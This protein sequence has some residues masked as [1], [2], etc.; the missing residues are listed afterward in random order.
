MNNYPGVIRSIWLLLLTSLGMGAMFAQPLMITAAWDGLSFEAFVDQTEAELK[1]RVF[2]ESFETSL[3]GPAT[4]PEPVALIP[5]LN[6]WLAPVGLSA[7][8]D[9]NGSVLVLSGNPIQAD[10]PQSIYP[11]SQPAAPRSPRDEPLSTLALS[12]EVI[13]KVFTVGTRRDGLGQAQV[14]LTGEVVDQESGEPIP[15]ASLSFLN[16]DRGA[17]TDEA[18]RFQISL[19]RGTHTLVIRNLGHEEASVSV[20]LLSAGFMTVQLVPRAIQLEDVVISSQQDDP[21][22][23][24]MMGFERIQARAAKEIPVVLGESDLLKV[25]NLLPG[26][27]NVGEGSGGYNVRGAP[28]D[29]NMFYLEQVPVYNTSHM[30]G[31]FSA[32]HSGALSGFSLYKSNIPSEY[33]GRLAATFELEAREANGEK[34]QLEG[35]ISPITGSMILGIPLKK[36]H[37]SALVSMRSTYSNWIL[38]QIPNEDFRNSNIY[39]GDATVLLSSQINDKNQLRIF[40]YGSLDDTQFGLDNSFQNQ[41]LGGSV[42]W[43]HFF[44][45]RNDMKVSLV[46]SQLGLDVADSTVRSEAYRMSNTLA[47]SEARVTFRLCPTDAH[48]IRLGANSIFYRNGRGEF[49]P[50]DGESLIS[51]IALGVEHGIESGVFIEDDWQINERISVQAGVRYNVYT[52]LGPAAVF[53][54]PEGRAMRESTVLDTVSYGS[55][56]PVKTW[57][58]LDWRVSS[59]LALTPN[60]SLKASLNRLHQFSFLMSNTIA[61][62]PT[63]KWKLADANIRPMVGD[64]ASLGLYGSFRGGLGGQFQAS[65]EGYVKRVRNLVEYRD[66]AN[67]LVS[68]V[69][70]WDVLQGDLRAYGLELMLRK[71]S[72]NVTGWVNYTYARSLVTVNGPAEDQKIN[73]GRP[74]PANFDRPHAANLSLAYRFSKQIG[75]A[76]NVVFAS[77]RP[78]TYPTT[79]YYLDGVKLVNFTTRNEYRLPDYFRIDIALNV[80]GNLL[81]KKLFHGSWSFGVYNLTGRDNVYT[82]YFSSA[83]GQLQGYKTS[84]FAIPVVSITYN[85]KLGN[86]DS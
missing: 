5:F 70:E 54:Y 43:L 8:A 37:T 55:L 14:S 76:C 34:F 66:G 29:Q 3:I 24:T 60:L 23:N 75:L 62:S 86:Y 4:V 49:G 7:T 39:F 78:I 38:R 15:Q 16:L 42:N 35:A 53:T 63:D 71:T 67:L 81:S 69:P 30:F 6:D 20:E 10:L 18:G 36:N 40:G 72:G 13:P 2:Y 21:V 25:A 57:Q 32:F 77:G 47:H 80:E 1:V 73:F 52:F 44:N 48:H 31:F 64:Q 85:F 83:S 58:G 11:G 46:H 22:Q 28:A 41:N 12:S 17:L 50:L 65:V 51:P 27:Q 61:L 19:P 74:Y 56:E 26:V 59:K 84:I 79:F 82:A 68:E 33:G 9:G 45:D